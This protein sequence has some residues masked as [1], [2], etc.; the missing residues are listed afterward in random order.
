MDHS[1]SQRL[2]QQNARYE[3]LPEN[4]DGASLVIQLRPLGVHDF[5]IV[6]EAFAVA[7]RSQLCGL[8]RGGDRLRL[9]L[10]GQDP[11]A[12]SDAV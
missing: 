3:S 11:N 7:H 6:R 9:G 2:D 5:Q 4:L 1:I 10:V 8:P 12:A